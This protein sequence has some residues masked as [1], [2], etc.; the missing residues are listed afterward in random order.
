MNFLH[1]LIQAVVTDS[2]VDPRRVRGSICLKKEETCDKCVPSKIESC[3]FATARH[4]RASIAQP[5]FTFWLTMS[6]RVG[7]R[8]HVTARIH[9]DQ[10]PRVRH[11]VLLLILIVASL[12]VLCA[13]AA[14][15]RSIQAPEMS[16]FRS[17]DYIVYRLEGN[18]TP[19][20]LAERF[21]GER[22]KSWLIT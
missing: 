12:L 6:P 2:G 1:L 8:G 5:V 13:C 14:T 20:E 16:L 22:K 21:L 19:A 7:V 18:E 3:S 10:L 15:G 11:V 4:V 17:E 9:G